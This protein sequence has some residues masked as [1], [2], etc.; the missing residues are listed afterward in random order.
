MEMGLQLLMRDGAVRLTFHPRLTA[1]QYAELVHIVELASTKDAL[2]KASEEAA[3]NWG[4]EVIF[5]DMGRS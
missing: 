1:D 4:V 3:A 2:R 5:E